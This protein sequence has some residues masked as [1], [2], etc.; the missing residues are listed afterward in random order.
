[1]D[2]YIV[3]GLNLSRDGAFLIAAGSIILAILTVLIAVITLFVTAKAIRSAA[4]QNLK[5][6]ELERDMVKEREANRWL[7]MAAGMGE[8]RVTLDDSKTVP[9]LN[10]QLIAAA[11]LG[12]YPNAKS[13]A[14]AL[15]GAM[16]TLNE[17]AATKIANELEK[18]I[19]KM[20]G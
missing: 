9:M 20:R 3:Y 5:S 2:D 16:S 7:L 8:A 10:V 12:S 11:M 4:E 1:M 6:K 18:S 15:L 19:S 17:P 13:G 14:E